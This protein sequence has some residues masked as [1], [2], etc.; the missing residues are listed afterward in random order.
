MDSLSHIFLHI[1]F[2]GAIARAPSGT[3]IP[4]HVSMT[5]HNGVTAL[6]KVYN[7]TR[8]GND[9]VIEF[10]VP[11]GVYRL[12]VDA[13]K[14]ACSRIDYLN[15][16]TGLNRNVKETLYD[17]PPPAQA[18]VSLV[19]GAAPA[20]FA[21]AKPTFVLFDASVTCDKPVND[22]LTVH[23]DVE[24]DQGSYH[25]WLFSDHELLAKGP[26]VVALRLQTTTGTAHYIRVRFP[27]PSPWY[28]WPST[29][30]LDISED[31]IDILATAKVDTLLCPKIWQ[32][33]VSG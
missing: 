23:T 33:S 21:Y 29:Y 12:I 19:D 32:T 18:N 10:D 2:C 16:L 20:S 8:D 5:Y 28:G 27:F 17:N 22:P 31:M 4:M 6:D 9:A 3:I 24:Y 25:L 26:V 11:A 7:V 14:Y 1:I 13:P 30:H 15:V